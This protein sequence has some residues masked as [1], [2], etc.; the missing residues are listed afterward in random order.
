MAS[1]ESHYIVVKLENRSAPIVALLFIDEGGTSHLHTAS[2]PEA[3]GAKDF[4]APLSLHSRIEWIDGSAEARSA[5][6]ASGAPILSA[7]ESQ[8]LAYGQA[9][10]KDRGARGGR[11]TKGQITPAKLK[12]VRKNW[13]KRWPKK[14]RKKDI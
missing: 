7:P 8:W 1:L 13:E 11:K 9:F 14:S 12:A 3:A 4:N 5:L 10:V 6:H 2:S